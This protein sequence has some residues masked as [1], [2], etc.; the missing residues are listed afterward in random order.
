MCI[1]GIELQKNRANVA[2]PNP[3][4][5]TT[6]AVLC[7]TPGRLSKSAKLSGTSPLNF[8]II[9][10]NTAVTHPVADFMI[11]WWDFGF[12][13]SSLQLVCTKEYK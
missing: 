1:A 4:A 2:H 7:P 5:I 13:R 10:C 6:E 8:S 3:C 12:T 9:I 11:N